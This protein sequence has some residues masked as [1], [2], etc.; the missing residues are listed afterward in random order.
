MSNLEE[1][2][3]LAEYPT[4]TTKHVKCKQPTYKC[5]TCSEHVC[6]R[7]RYIMYF[8]I[9]IIGSICARCV[10]M[11]THFTH[12]GKTHNTREYLSEKT[13]DKLAQIYDPL[14]KSCK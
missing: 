2:C 1:K 12:Y 11:N 9:V 13:I 5:L 6:D 8:G 14:I 10:A 3:V 4:P 7:H